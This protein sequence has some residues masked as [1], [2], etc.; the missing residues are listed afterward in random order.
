MWNPSFLRRLTDT[1]LEALINFKLKVFSTQLLSFSGSNRA[2]DLSIAIIFL[3]HWSY[4]NHVSTVFTDCD[5]PVPHNLYFSSRC[6]WWTLNSYVFVRWVQILSVQKLSLTELFGLHVFDRR[7]YF[8]H[9]KTLDIL[10]SAEGNKKVRFRLQRYYMLY[11]SKKKNCHH[12]LL[13]QWL[14]IDCLEKKPLYFR[15]S[16]HLAC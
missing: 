12:H 2:S 3:R 4:S 13:V 5:A 15:K 9:K 6:S 14:S 10:I 7:C 1:K 16:A 8:W 11:S